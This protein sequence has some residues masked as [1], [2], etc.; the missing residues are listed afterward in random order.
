M[1]PLLEMRGI[2]K[3]YP[4]V[5]ALSS[6]DFTLH[7][8]EVH[9]LV[10]ENGAGKS[11]LIKVLS[12]AVM[13]DGGTISVGGEDARLESPADAQRLGIGV[14]YQD[15]KLVPALSVA[16]NILLGSEPVRGRTPIIDRNAMQEKAS[17][18][19]AQLGETIDTGTPVGHLSV[20]Q[21]QMVEIAK[22]LSRNVR[23]LA[24]DEPTAPLTERETESLFR[25]IRSLKE[26]GVGIIYISHRLEEIFEVGDRV[27]VLR[28]GTLVHTCAISEIDRRG[29]IR[30]MVGRELE[31]EYPRAAL[32]RGKE[33]LRIENLSSDRISNV[34]LTL[35]RGEVLGLAG[36]VGAGRS[37]L[38]RLVF[39]AD[40]KKEGRIFLDGRE[41]APESPHQAIREGI[42]LLTEDRNRY[43]LIM[44]MSIRENISLANLR[45]MLTGPFIDRRK[46]ESA[47]RQLVEDLRIKAPGTGVIVE[48]LSGGN[49]QKVVLAR[50]LNTKARVLIFD[51]PTAGIDVGVKF[52]IYTLINRLAERGIGVIVIS[53]DLPELLGMCH[54]VAVMCEGRLTGIVEG[55][56]ATQEAVMTYAHGNR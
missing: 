32:E 54:R 49:R 52:E 7:P 34:N 8:G 14:I 5:L 24:M 47:A 29:L 28:D 26:R 17:A 35:Y 53:S 18:A 40:R 13:K 43:G 20:A 48:N 27:T 25:V 30:R 16:E 11:T 10:G 51:E 9:C 55:A 19:L 41:I 3:R 33:I 31:N 42:G 12:G 36:L 56:E 22:A 37:E 50:W 45:A 23:I 4:G 44:Q 2:T 39:G 1:A 38:A 6:V 15:F 46:E 21:Q